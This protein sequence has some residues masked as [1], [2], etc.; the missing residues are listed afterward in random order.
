MGPDPFYFL[1]IRSRRSL[2]T[3]PHHETRALNPVKTAA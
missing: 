2:G 3:E 1:K